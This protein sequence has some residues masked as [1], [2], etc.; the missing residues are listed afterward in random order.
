MGFFKQ[1][2]AFVV[3]TPKVVDDVF[4]KDNGLVAKAGSFINDLNYTEAEKAKGFASLA[5]AVS[6]HIA[7]TLSESTVRSKTRREL[8]VQ[9]I[10]VQLGLVLLTAIAIPFNKLTAKEFFAL[11]TCDVMLYGT[12]SIIVFF[13]GAYVWGTHIRNKDKD[14]GK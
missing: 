2:L 14:K 8:A 3:G 13:F 9:W 6:D 1:L 12:G 10:R 11:A 5:K 4:D 7:S